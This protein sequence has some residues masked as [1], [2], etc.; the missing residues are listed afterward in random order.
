MNQTPILGVDI[1]KQKIDVFF[2]PNS[3]H[4]CYSNDN[5]GF[6]AL[7]KRLKKLKNKAKI[8]MEA[9]GGYER[10]LFDFFTELGFTCSIVN[11]KR[12]RDFARGLGL[13]AKTDKID[14]LAIAR[15]GQV[16]DPRPTLPPSPK[17]K[18]LHAICVR[19]RALIK[20]KSAEQNR[21][22]LT[23][24]GD[25]LNSIKGLLKVLKAEIRS[26]DK[27][28]AELTKSE[29]GLKEKSDRLQS[30]PGVGP[31]TATMILSEL[32]E[33]GRISNKEIAALVGL[34][35]FSVES[36]SYVGQRHIRGGRESVRQ[37][38][39]MAAFVASRKNKVLKSFYEG[40]RTRGKGHKVALVAVCRKLLVILNAMIRKGEMWSS[41]NNFENCNLTM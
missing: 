15:Y 40:L 12:I 39:F 7:H 27:K 32:P 5:K 28:L 31:K 3:S 38:L 14:A 30:V 13:L 18:R 23:K 35:P 41:Q 21:L 36:G 26:L 6:K 2:L 10:D 16:V 33:I 8:V 4:A 24:D 17:Q 19:R 37:C 29:K 9:S 1:A 25:S 34:A 11:P 20:M 22:R